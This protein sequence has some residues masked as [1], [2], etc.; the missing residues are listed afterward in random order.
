MR[1]KVD[2]AETAEQH[3]RE[4]AAYFE[5]VQVESRI[6]QKIVADLRDAI[7]GLD[8][9]PHRFRRWQDDCR[10]SNIVRHLQ[11]GNY[12]ILFAVDDESRTVTVIAILHYRQNVYARFLDIYDDSVNQN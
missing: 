4:I 12:V 8:F 3:L 2:L 5:S 9:M 11:C 1:Y 7:S 6:V 10:M